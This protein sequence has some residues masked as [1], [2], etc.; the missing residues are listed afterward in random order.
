MRNYFFIAIGLFVI[1][2]SA[3]R[4]N[5][6]VVQHERIDSTAVSYREVEKIV[7]VPGDSVKAVMQVQSKNENKKNADLNDS[8][9]FVPQIQQLETKRTKVTIELT[10]S[11]EIKATAISKEL[12]EKVTILEKTI[13]NYH[14]EVTVSE[15]KESAFKRFLNGVKKTTNTIF[16]TIA[17]LLG[18]YAFIRFRSVLKSFVYKIIK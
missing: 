13:S 6:Q 4:S 16:Y 2:L 12:D 14:R 3:C 18:L 9:T 15:Q 8:Q 1:L 5:R 17:I 11:G 7:H 10:E